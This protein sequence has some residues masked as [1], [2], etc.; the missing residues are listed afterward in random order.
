MVA[1]N[2]KCLLYKTLFKESL[3]F[4]INRKL[5]LIKKKIKINNYYSQFFCEKVLLCNSSFFPYYIHNV[6]LFCI[7]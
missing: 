3:H 2:S 5:I 4:V 7:Q 6:Y 1:L